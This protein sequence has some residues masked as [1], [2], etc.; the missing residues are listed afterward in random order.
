VKA[1]A[2]TFPGQRIYVPWAM[3]EAIERFAANFTPLIGQT[4]VDALTSEF[5]GMRITVP[6]MRVPAR[7]KG[8]VPVD[9]AAVASMTQDEQLT[10]GQIAHRLQCDPRSVHKART[11]ARRLGLLSPKPRKKGAR[12]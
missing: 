11:K 12:R 4:A 1:L 6:T 2:R 7:A 5:G 3:P 9:V 8:F 10:A